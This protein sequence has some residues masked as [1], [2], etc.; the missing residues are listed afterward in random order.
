MQSAKLNKIT[1]HHKKAKSQKEQRSLDFTRNTETCI[2]DTKTVFILGDALEDEYKSM[3][4]K[5]FM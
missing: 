5:H 1:D 4:K 3:K 2:K